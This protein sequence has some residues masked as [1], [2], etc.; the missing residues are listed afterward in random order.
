MYKFGSLLI[1]ETHTICAGPG[2]YTRAENLDLTFSFLKSHRRF[3][4]VAY[5]L[6]DA[7]ASTV[8]KSEPEDCDTGGIR[9]FAGNASLAAMRA[10]SPRCLPGMLSRMI[11]AVKAGPPA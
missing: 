7:V 5:G 4:G 3:P 10:T 8:A 2:G 1:D 6:T 11:P 9:N